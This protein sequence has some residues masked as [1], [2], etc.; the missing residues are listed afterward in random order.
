MKNINWEDDRDI[1]GRMHLLTG[2]RLF[3]RLRN[4]VDHCNADLTDL[5]TWGQL[6]SKRWIIEELE[7]I[8]E[9]HK[10]NLGLIFICAGWYGSLAAMLFNSKCNINKIR[11]FDIDPVCLEI[12]DT[13]NRKQEINNWQFKAITKDIFDIN[14]AKETWTTWSRANNR[15]SREFVETPNTV[16]NTSCEHIDKF[17][18]WYHKIPKGTLVCLQSNDYFDVPKETGHVNCCNNLIEFQAQTPMS[19][20]LY[21]GVLDLK[22]YNRFMR[23]GIR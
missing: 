10:I 5:L 9:K 21:E 13:I 18:D 6:K 14:Y 1:Y 4:A 23:I 11:S 20:C 22:K 8:T 17:Y 3:L 7:N 2:D 19:E 12:A 16:I 15:M